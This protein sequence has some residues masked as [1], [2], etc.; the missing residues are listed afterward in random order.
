MSNERE[1]YQ[2]AFNVGLKMGFEAA[3]K[4]ALSKKKGIC[5]SYRDGWNAACNEI[6]DSIEAKSNE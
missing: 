4:I 1:E 5:D 3:V 6:A 2:K